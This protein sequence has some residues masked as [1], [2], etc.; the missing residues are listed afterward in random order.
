[1]I[2]D[3][4]AAAA[5]LAT[6]LA[7]GRARHRGRPW[8]PS[9]RTLLASCGG[10]PGAV[11][12]PAGTPPAPLA[13]LPPRTGTHFLVVDDRFG[14]PIH[15][16][17]ELDPTAEPGFPGFAVRAVTLD[18]A[19]SLP[20]LGMPAGAA[21]GRNPEQL[22]RFRA[23]RSDRA[24]AGAGFILIEPRYVGPSWPAYVL[25]FRP[26][27]RSQAN[28]RARAGRP[29]PVG[30]VASGLSTAARSPGPTR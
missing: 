7:L 17:L 20:G 14:T 16:F 5:D 3:Q 4:S 23:F 12:V 18:P 10:P 24:A 6:A 19:A 8:G 29:A 30:P 28:I 2:P 1:M 26:G 15:V 25:A 21:I 11:G 27:G 13:A 9:A 22:D